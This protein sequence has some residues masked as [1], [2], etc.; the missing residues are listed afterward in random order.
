MV[1]NKINGLVTFF[2][3]NLHTHEALKCVGISDDNDTDHA[4]VSSEHPPSRSICMTL[5]G[6][7]KKSSS[8][9]R[10][11]RDAMTPTHDKVSHLSTLQIR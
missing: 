7:T 10:S 11:D 9:K 2:P 6:T 5:L 4:N 8:S 3:S 1:C